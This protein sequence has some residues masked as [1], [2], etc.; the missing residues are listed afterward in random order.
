MSGCP[1]DI[2]LFGLV[3]DFDGGVSWQE[4]DHRLLGAWLHIQLCQLSLCR[5]LLLL[6]LLQ[7]NNLQTPGWSLIAL[8]LF[9]VRVVFE[10]V[11]IEMRSETTFMLLIH[12]QI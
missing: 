1:E 12:F 6:I 8:R 9:K 4:V 7:L 2:L 10:F 11:V 3:D 5:P